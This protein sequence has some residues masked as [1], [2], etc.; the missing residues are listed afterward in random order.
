MQ[1]V[2]TEKQARQI[3]GGRKP[4]VPVEYEEACRQLEACRTLDEAKYWDN[5]ADALAA[6][7]KI[8]H[9]NKAD[10]EARAL[11][12]W[13]YRRMGELAQDLQPRHMLGPC[14]GSAP[15]P[16]ALLESHGLSRSKAT[17]ARRLAILTT[18]EVAAIAAT[19]RPPSPTHVL[20]KYRSPL[21][22]SQGGGKQ[23]FGSHP[24]WR[25]TWEH[26]SS[27]MS[28]IVK[29]DAAELAASVR[30]DAVNRVR[31][32]LMPLIEWLDKFEQ[33]LPKE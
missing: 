3:T 33:H 24:L 6:W 11:K 28:R 17:A 29:T 27:T 19:P 25:D 1:S 7:A 13:A 2:I 32:R 8:Y 26:I 31:E 9:D 20:P 23:A 5:K 22:A 16:V 15:G 4:H 18:D 10:R 12:L 21:F 30:P 14:K